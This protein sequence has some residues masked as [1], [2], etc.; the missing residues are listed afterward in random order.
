MPKHEIPANR[1]KTDRHVT[2][3]LQ[4]EVGADKPIRV[5][6]DWGKVVEIEIEGVTAGQLTAAVNRARAAN[7]QL[8]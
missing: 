4:A 1:A 3:E 6:M 2:D 5:L 7:P 8:F